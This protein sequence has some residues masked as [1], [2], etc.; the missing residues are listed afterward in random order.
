ML[1][2]VRAGHNEPFLVRASGQFERVDAGSLPLGIN[3]NETYPA[4]EIPLTSDDLLLIYSDGLV[5]AVNMREQEFGEER[6][7]DVLKTAPKE[8]AG[9]TLQRLLA[10]VRTFTGQ[11]RQYDDLTAFVVRG[12]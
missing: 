5:E 2:Y 4:E 7:I 6:V 8:T 11:R 12:T 10:S 9:Q 3:V 1:T